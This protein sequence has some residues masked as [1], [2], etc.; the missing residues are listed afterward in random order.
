MKTINK[1]NP[2]FLYQVNGVILDSWK[3]VKHYTSNLGLSVR[4]MTKTHSPFGRVLFIVR[5]GLSD[6]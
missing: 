4:G 3:E 1:Y 5:T 6:V 2:S